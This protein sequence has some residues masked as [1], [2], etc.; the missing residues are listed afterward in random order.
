MVKLDE[1]IP[2]YLVKC[3]TAYTSAGHGT[4]QL[5]ETLLERITTQI[6]TL[7]YSDLIKFF[8]VFPKVT[9]IY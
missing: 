3:L 7:K 6:D 4:G 9:H 1:C 5:Y 8:E 2:H